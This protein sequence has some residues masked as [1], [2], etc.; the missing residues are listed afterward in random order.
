[1]TVP[2]GRQ[3]PPLFFFIPETALAFLQEV[4]VPI[5]FDP[6]NLSEIVFYASKCLH[7]PQKCGKI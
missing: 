2:S 5:L 7:K 1:M 6:V 3:K 4:E